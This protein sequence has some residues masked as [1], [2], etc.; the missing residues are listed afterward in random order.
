[1]NITIGADE[2]LG[3]KLLGLVPQ[4]RVHVHALDEGDDLSAGRDRVTVHL[5]FS[6]GEKGGRG[7]EQ[8]VVRLWRS[9][10]IIASNSVLE[11]VR[12]RSLCGF[13]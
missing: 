5:D 3:D 9:L 10:G 6:A 1:M 13:I 11:A 7:E 4:R 12:T 2:A 8:E